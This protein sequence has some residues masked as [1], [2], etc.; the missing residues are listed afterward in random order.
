ML[1]KTIKVPPKNLPKITCGRETGFDKIKSI[2]PFSKSVGIKPATEK[3]D[4]NNPPA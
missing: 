3:I 1:E 4:K 2:F